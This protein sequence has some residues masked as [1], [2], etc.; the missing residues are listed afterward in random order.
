M[1]FR[2]FPSHDKVKENRINKEFEKM[3]EEGGA[4]D[5][6]T[7]KLRRNYEKVTPGQPVKKN[8]LAQE[9]DPMKPWPNLPVADGIGPE[10]SVQPYRTFST[11][12]MTESIKSWV[13][14]SKTQQKFKEK[15]GDLWEQKLLETAS[16]LEK[17]GCG[18]NQTNKK[19]ITK[20]KESWT[21]AP[22][23]STKTKIR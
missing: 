1:L 22:S 19:T 5:W 14:N 4:G 12:T 11:L 15:Y 17:A 9:E 2:S 6:G 8:V 18:S 20:L 13:E 7:N 16:L 23:K 10:I 21:S 3:T